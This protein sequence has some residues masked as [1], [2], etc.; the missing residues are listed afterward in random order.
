MMC[1]DDLQLTL[2]QCWQGV[3]AVE[4]SFV[5]R[6]YRQLKK[7]YQ[8]RLAQAGRAHALCAGTVPGKSNLQIH[9]SQRLWPIGSRGD[10]RVPT[11]I[12]IFC[13]GPTARRRCYLCAVKQSAE[14]PT[15]RVYRTSG[16]RHYGKG[17]GFRLIAPQPSRAR[18]HRVTQ[19]PGQG[20]PTPIQ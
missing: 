14:R 10:N 20:L 4:I 16:H 13:E 17:G 1:T 6:A 12:W 18:E 3:G 2:T 15:V 5:S 11:Q 19:V 9:R 8:C 7:R